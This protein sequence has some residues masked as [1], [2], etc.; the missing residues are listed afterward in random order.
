M[1]MGEEVG[2]VQVDVLGLQKI[3]FLLKNICYCH[4]PRRLG[5]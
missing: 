4:W 5:R 2:D 1:G 3:I